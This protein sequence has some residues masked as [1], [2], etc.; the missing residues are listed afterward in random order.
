MGLITQLIQKIIQHLPDEILEDVNK[1]SL[2]E[3]DHRGLI[4][5]SDQINAESL[6]WEPD[7]D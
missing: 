2:E 3:L 6:I 1:Y 7:C 5:W 4:I